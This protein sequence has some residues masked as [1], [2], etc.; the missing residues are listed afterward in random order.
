M[1]ETHLAK[2][3]RNRI[4]QYQN[5]TA[6]RFKKDG[7]YKSLSWNELGKQI[8]SV[9]QY[10]IS[11]GINTNS[12]IGIYSQNCPEWSIT[13]FAILSIRS[14][15]VPIF[16]T[17]TYEQ[18]KYIVEETEMEV[19]FVSD[20]MQLSNAIKALKNCKSL[21]KIISFNCHK[22]ENT[23][24]TLF[25]D[26]LTNTYDNN[27]K[28]ILN[29]RLSQAN[30][31]DLA[32]IIYTSG[33]TG[34]PKG[35]MLHHSNFIKLFEIHDIRLE[36]DENDVS[37]AFLPLS[38]VFERGW[39][40]FVF[41]KGA[42]NVY[43]YNPKDIINE[44]PLVKPT[45][46][47][48]VPR[49]FEKSYDIISKTTQKWNKPKRCFF[50]WALNTGLQFIEYEKDCLRPPAILNY[51][52]KLANLLVMKTFRNI[53]GGRIKYMPCAGA[54]LNLDI[55]KFFHALGIKINYGYGATETS[56]TVSCMKKDKYD[57]VNTGSIM[58]DVQVK[59][60]EKDGQILVKGETVF[61]GYYKK[62]EATGEA[63][64]DGWYYTGDQGEI[65]QD[66]MLCMKE[67]IKD[68][69]KTSTGKYVSPQKIELLLSQDHNIEQLCVI[70]DNRKYLT[71]LIVPCYHYLKSLYNSNDNATDI[72]KLVS[73][74]IAINE[75]QKKLDKL[76]VE[77]ASY[78]KV[79]NFKLLPKPFTVE[80]NL[81]TNSLKVRR[82]QVNIEYSELIEEMY[83]Q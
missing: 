20:E 11:E 38:H 52:Y 62:P 59:I 42:T 81:M 13:D 15:V 66:G 3:I 61:K 67:R 17:S 40:Y 48:A 7:I 9:S 36:L 34:E 28:Q 47:C 73:N 75:Y 57:F 78:E 44:L 83:N 68:I 24:I 60:N 65:T 76:Q 26:I 30:I 53:F 18:L 37:L 77:L 33:T 22:V 6:V 55:L 12:N 31:N 39:T 2:I 72:E 21:K 43:N 80:N 56:A 45:V 79:V 71:A 46:M 41:Y 23:Q 1:K 54:A 32:T 19:L 14:V 70:G 10:L 25:N 49:F 69:M 74:P 4:Q 82:K 8:D 51:K 58:P 63:L 16:P 35:V 5:K 29:Q 50:N 27:S 64:K